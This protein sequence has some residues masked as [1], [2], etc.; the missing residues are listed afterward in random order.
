MTLYQPSNVVGT[1]YTR[2]YRV[3]CQNPLDG[4]TSITFAEQSVVNLDD[5]TV[6]TKDLGNLNEVLTEENTTTEFALL[7]PVTGEST[8]QSMSYGDIFTALYSLYI[9]LATNRDGGSTEQ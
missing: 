4:Q 8:G 9:D 7:N 2:A 1:K 3:E 6:I 5:G